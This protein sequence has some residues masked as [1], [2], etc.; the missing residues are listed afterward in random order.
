M[1]AQQKI[2]AAENTGIAR[3][4][5]WHA[6][7]KFSVVLTDGRMGTGTSFEDAL[8]AACEPDAE[9]VLQVAA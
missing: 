1:T 9:N 6:L 8:A 3:S 4:R 7:G 2:V 5:Y